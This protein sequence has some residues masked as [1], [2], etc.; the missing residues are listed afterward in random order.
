MAKTPGGCILAVVYIHCKAGNDLSID[1]FN[2]F[3]YFIIRNLANF[4][5]DV[6]FFISGF[7]VKPVDNNVL[8]YKKRLP[9]L[10]FPYLFYSVIY[11]IVKF[12]SKGSIG[13]KTII[14]GLFLGTA[15]VPFYYIVV[16]VYFTLLTPYL[17]K[18]IHNKAISILIMSS[19][20]VFIVISH[21]SKIYS[22][23]IIDFGIKYSPIWLSFYYLGMLIKYYKPN[24]NKKALWILLGG[25]FL[26]ELAGT[27][28]L[29]PIENFNA[30]TQL[31][32]GG[33][34][35]AA[36]IVLLVYEYSKN[37]VR[38]ESHKLLC[39]LGDDSYP[40]YYIHCL[41]ISLYGKVIEYKDSMILPLYVFIQLAFSIFI[42]EIIII[43]LKKIV[44]EKKM[45]IVLGI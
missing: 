37:E 40:M 20:P 29:M 17:Q 31:R 15:A 6:F 16:L 19:T 12:I 28:I 7:F 10:I 23:G 2:G 27:I 26:F 30:Y 11:L 9:K 4:P 14:G 35:Y 21:L 34:F 43:T 22:I 44:T 24:F 32:F 1:T 13:V 18:C 5:V 33:M 45:K 42:C 39:R 8:Y 3:T 41:I 38:K 25:S 36:A